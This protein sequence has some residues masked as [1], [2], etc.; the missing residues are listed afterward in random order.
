MY[1]EFFGLRARPFGITP[2]AE[3]YFHS[4]AHRRTL[5]C[6]LGHVIACEPLIVLTGEIGAGKTTALQVLLRNLPERFVPALL[7]STQLDSAELTRSVLFAFGVCPTDEPLD[8]LRIALRSRLADLRSQ[9]QRGLLVVDEAQNLSAETLR[10]L[11][12]LPELGGG[13]DEASLQVIISGQPGLRARAFLVEASG[14]TAGHE[15]P[16]CRLRPMN[17]KDTGLY[18]RHRLRLA[19]STGGPTFSEDAIDQV[20]QATGGL[21]RLVNRLCERLLTA[22]YLE[23]SRDIDAV[24]VE[25]AA[26]EL[27]QELGDSGVS[28]PAVDPPRPVPP[29]TSMS[30]QSSTASTVVGAKVDLEPAPPVPSLAAP[31]PD[32][33]QDDPAPIVTDTPSPPASPPGRR[34]RPWIAIAGAAS[35]LTVL[36]GWLVNDRLSPPNM[37]R[38]SASASGSVVAPASRAD[39][40][41]AARIPDARSNSLSAD[42]SASAALSVSQ[43]PVLSEP[44]ENPK[45]TAPPSPQLNAE[46]A[47]GLASSTEPASAPPT[48][49]PACSAAAKALGLCP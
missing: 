43:Q 21:P 23:Q 36:I 49:A 18:V 20:Q 7:V 37:T 27:R 46:A 32:V 1:E 12:R 29:A 10:Y 47:L 5:A 28:V 22:A 33:G 38:P 4:A 30:L 15:L 44:R 25:R 9:S 11:M 39:A 13:D 14:A 2:S 34:R 45:P 42:S 6:L 24:D 16:L 40:S 3:L 17:A 48:D 41:A 26:A 8:D 19:G 31:S 35:L